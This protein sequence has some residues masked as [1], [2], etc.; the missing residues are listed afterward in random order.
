MLVSREGNEKLFEGLVHR[1]FLNLE[2][3]Y[4]LEV[5][6]N[7]TKGNIK[8]SNAMSRRWKRS[9]QELYSQAMENL[10]KDRYE[11]ISVRELVEEMMGSAANVDDE[12]CLYVLLS[13]REYYGAAGV[14]NKEVL[15]MC[16]EKV[17]NSF[18]LLPSSVHEWMV[19]P[20]NGHYLPEELKVMVME[21]N[22]EQ[23]VPEERLADAV[24][25]YQ[26]KSGEV[27]LAV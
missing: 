25:Y 14:L 9:E 2:I 20:D 18:Y 16:E 3:I 23:V 13:E 19:V 15:K 24:Y 26:E 6:V 7:E 11:L 4:Y 21:V 27:Q 8:V 1:P 10:E 5:D 22:R 12:V 17:G